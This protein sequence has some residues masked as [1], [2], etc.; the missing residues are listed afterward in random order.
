MNIQDHNLVACHIGLDLAVSLQ[1]REEMVKVFDA[2]VLNAKIINN[3]AELYWP[4]FVFP[5]IWCC[6]G[7]VVALLF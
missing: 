6:S 7:F 4:P 2:H 3:E 1:D 5:N